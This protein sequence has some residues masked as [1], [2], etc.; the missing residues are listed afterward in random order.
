[1]MTIG[2]GGDNL[3]VY[4]PL[5]AQSH[6]AS[7]LFLFVLFLL[8]VAVWCLIGYGLTRLPG[9]ETILGRISFAAFPFLLIGLGLFIVW[10]AWLLQGLI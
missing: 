7:I 2:N 5:F 1:M 8:L 4:I 3:S 6:G 10:N 9:V